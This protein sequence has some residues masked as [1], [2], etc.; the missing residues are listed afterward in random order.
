MRVVLPL[1]L[2]GAAPAWAG[3]P[4]VLLQWTEPTCVDTA[5]V[6]SARRRLTGV[7]GDAAVEGSTM[8]YRV[9]SNGCEVWAHAWCGKAPDAPAPGMTGVVA[10]P[11]IY[12][13]KD[14]AG[15][16]LALGEGRYLLKDIPMRSGGDWN[17]KAG[18]V[19]VPTG[20]AVRLCQEAGGAGKCSDFPEDLQDLGT[21]YV[22]NDTASWAVVSKGAATGAQR[23]PRAFEHDNFGGKMLEVC[24]DQPDL[25]QIG[26]ND[27][28]SSVVVPPGWAVAVCSNPAGAPPCVELS[29]DTPRLNGTGVEPDTASSLRILRRPR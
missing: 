17:D 7:C 26:W 13:D 16:A 10:V 11:T 18:S 15:M 12:A 8:Q 9:V 3:T 6:A 20:W 4:D 24:E 2:L 28:I 21:T 19:R 1:L 25:V 14:F 23:C 5:V 22:G 27:K 29:A